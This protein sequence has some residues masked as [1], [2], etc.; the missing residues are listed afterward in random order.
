M[1]VLRVILLQ[2]CGNAGEVDNAA[3]VVAGIGENVHE[4]FHSHSCD[5]VDASF[6]YAQLTMFT[7]W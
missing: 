7:N 6:R 2:V 5:N 1:T 4:R 3:A